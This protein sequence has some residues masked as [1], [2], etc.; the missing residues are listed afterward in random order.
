MTDTYV[1][2]APAYVEPT[3]AGK[4]DLR[5]FIRQYVKSHGGKCERSEVAKACH[6][7]FP[8]AF[9]WGE[10]D[11]QLDRVQAKWDADRAAALAAAVGG[12]P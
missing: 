11:R 1:E 3:E 5:V 8:G 7:Q 12:T 6:Q 10:I 2:P 4:D 9:T